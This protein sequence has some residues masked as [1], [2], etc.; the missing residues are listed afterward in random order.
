MDESKYIGKV[1]TFYVPSHKLD[2]IKYGD[3]GLTPRQMFHETFMMHYQ[4]YTH[5][6]SKIQGYWQGGSDM[7]RD[8]HE[9]YEVAVCGKSGRKYLQTFMAYMCGLLQEE[10]IY[11]TVGCKAWLVFPLTSSGAQD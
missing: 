11:L 1:A 10:S 4:A 3:K 5:E 7:E 9:R 2:D 8:E 6:V